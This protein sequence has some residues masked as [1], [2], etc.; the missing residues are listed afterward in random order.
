MKEA[1]LEVRPG[2]RCRCG[3]SRRSRSAIADYYVEQ[4]LPQRDA[5]IT[6]SRT[7]RRPRRSSIFVI[8]EGDKIKIASI[9]VRRATTSFR[10]AAPAQRDAQDEGQ[11]AGG[12]SSPKRARS[13]ARPT[14]TR[15]SR[16]SRAL[17][18]SKGY[19]DVVVKDPVL[20]VFVK[21]PKDAAK[22][23]KKRGPDH[24]PVVEGDQFFT[25]KIQI[26]KRGP[27]RPARQSADARW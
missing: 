15:T 8:D 23:Q 25:G 6:G 3:R 5:S 16:A 18:Q 24:D 20:D 22:K 13:T 27:D 19:K 11:H 17:Y 4:R 10:A 14:T 9:H 12:A 7:S 21:N 26:I 1:K 2:A